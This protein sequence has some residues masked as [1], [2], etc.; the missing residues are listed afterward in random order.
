MNSRHGTSFQVSYLLVALNSNF[1]DPIISSWMIFKPDHQGMLLNH[2]QAMGDGHDFIMIQ[3]FLE[4]FLHYNFRSISLLT[5]S[6]Y[7]VS[8]IKYAYLATIILHISP[9]PRPTVIAIKCKP[10]C[11]MWNFVRVVKP[12]FLSIQPDYTHPMPKNKSQEKLKH[13]TSTPWDQLSNCHGSIG[14]CDI[15]T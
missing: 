9:K 4:E 7:K 1:T 10:Q 12:W 11:S 3:S 5:E 8:G 14:H 6:S 2:K 13:P 15:E